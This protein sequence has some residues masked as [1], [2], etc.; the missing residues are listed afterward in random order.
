MCLFLITLGEPV[1]Y[2]VNQVDG[3][4]LTIEKPT[5]SP[6]KGY[7]IRWAVTA[8]SKE[9]YSFGEDGSPG[10]E[11]LERHID[12]QWYRLTYSQDIFP[13]NSHWV[14]TVR[15]CREVLFKNMIIMELAWRREPIV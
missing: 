4:E 1:S 12:G 2:P 6:F 3:F 7:T 10:F 15:A 9:I 5:W 14:E 11:Y 13:F 8:N